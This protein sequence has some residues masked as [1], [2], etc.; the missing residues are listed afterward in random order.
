MSTLALVLAIMGAA[1]AVRPNND[2]DDNIMSALYFFGA[3][4]IAALIGGG[5]IS[6]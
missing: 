2:Y 6:A 1:R 5:V 3:V 4:L